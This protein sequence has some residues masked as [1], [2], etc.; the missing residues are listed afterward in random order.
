MMKTANEVEIYDSWGSFEGIPDGEAPASAAALPKHSFGHRGLE[1]IGLRVPGFALAAGLAV[2]A[3]AAAAWIGH[4]LL[5]YEVSPLSGVPI[6]ILMGIILCNSLGVPTVFHAGLRACTQQLQRLAIMLLGFRLS[7]G[8]VGSIGLGALPIVI[9]SI[10]AA[11]IFVPWLGTKVGLSRRLASLIAVGT[12]ICGVSAIMA[13]APTIKAED[14]EI[15]Y[16]I[17]CVAIFG[18]LAMLVYPYVTP[19]LFGSDRGGIGIFF[20]TAI[21]DTAQV[22]GAALVFEQLHEAP[23]VLNI[24]TVVKIMRN[25]SMIA[26]IPIMAAMFHRADREGNAPATRA[27]L[28]QVVPLFVIGFLVMT[29]VRT[30]GDMSLRP[31]G[32]LESLQWH[33]FLAKIDWA[34]TWFLT[35]VMAAVGLGTGLARLRRLGLRPF[36][37]GLSAALLVGAVSYGLIKLF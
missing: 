35:V 11:L 23:E 1:W 9:I 33:Q 2:A 4:D 32:L 7:M 26:V 18:M 5:G 29:I 28:G 3:D 31:F 12:S 36:F 20:G 17:A 37:V 24:A 15:S 6:A 10:A 14:E 30:V 22:T 16:A 8:M 21:H 25:L 27:K 19:A 34:S 13:V